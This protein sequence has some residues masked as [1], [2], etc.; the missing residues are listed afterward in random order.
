M[1]GAGFRHV[2]KAGSLRGEAVR[3]YVSV[4]ARQFGRGVQPGCNAGHALAF[5]L[6]PFG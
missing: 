3:R 1:P 2:A 5:L 4:E 6:P